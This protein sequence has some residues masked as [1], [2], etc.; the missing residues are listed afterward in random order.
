MPGARIRSSKPPDLSLTIRRA[1]CILSTELVKSYKPDPRT[2]QLVPSLLAVRPEQ[3][4]MVAA[5][6][7]DLAAAAEQGFRT[8]FV[9]GRRFSRPCLETLTIIMVMAETLPLATVK[10]RLSE[11][12]DRISKQ[13]D[14][15]IV[16]RNGRPAV[17]L[18][19]P[20]DLES[21]EE[22]LAVLSDPKL[23][24][25][26]REGRRAASTGDVVPVQSIRTRRKRAG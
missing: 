1:D 18:L 5:H 6:P 10:A 22:T 4:V 3:V 24:R 25:Q 14:R 7:Y 8:A 15:V 11:I 2:Y 21:L 23:L 17:V 19:S 13:Q 16:T 20:D 12:I 26:V 9:H